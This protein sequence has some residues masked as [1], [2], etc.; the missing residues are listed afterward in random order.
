VVFR[1]IQHPKLGG[2]KRFFLRK[3]AF[4]RKDKYFRRPPTTD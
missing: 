2:M 3:F 1:G 4:P